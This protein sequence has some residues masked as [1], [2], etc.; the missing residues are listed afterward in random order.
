MDRDRRSERRDADRPTRN[1]GAAPDDR[2]ITGMFSNRET[3]ERAYN[4][5]K[6]RGYSDDEISLLMSED[7]RETHFSDENRDETE[8]GNKALEGTGAGS[9]IGGTAGA[10]AGILAAVGTSVAIPGLGIVIA[11]PIAAGLAGAGAGGIA[12]GLIGALIGA[13]IPEER[14]ETYEEGVEEG[15]IVMG[16]NPR[17]HEDA[18]YI[19]NDWRNLQAEE[20]QY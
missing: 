20:V 12:G 19:K 17:T 4:N 8:M 13:G 1:Q 7:T 2:M 10:A 5:M 16:V 18:E 3:A 6:D 9:A 11:G 14:A 15:K